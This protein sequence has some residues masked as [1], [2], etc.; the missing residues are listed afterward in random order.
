M[1]HVA[2]SGMRFSIE[3]PAAAVRLFGFGSY[4]RV[5]PTKYRERLSR[6]KDTLSF[7]SLSETARSQSAIATT[8]EIF[9]GSIEL[10]TVGVA[11]GV[12]PGNYPV[13]SLVQV[14]TRH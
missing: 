4:R 3:R 14:V 11:E 9:L 1:G 12:S 10:K 8:S 7:L 6:H 5:F 13:S 2:N